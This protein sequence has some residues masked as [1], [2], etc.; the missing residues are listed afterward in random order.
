MAQLIPNLD[1]RGRSVVS[2]KLPGFAKWN[3]SV[4]GPWK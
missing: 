2:F 3:E 4:G 1:T